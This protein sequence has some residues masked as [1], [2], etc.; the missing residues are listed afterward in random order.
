M[1]FINL[2]SLILGEAE[3]N[4][5]I[6]AGGSRGV[7]KK[8]T[9]LTAKPF[10]FMELREE[11]DTNIRE[12]LKKL[13]DIAIKHSSKEGNE[14]FRAFC[15]E[16]K[17]R[18]P[19]DFLKKIF[20]NLIAN[21]L[22]DFR[23][24]TSSDV[25]TMESIV[26]YTLTS[27]ETNLTDSILQGKARKRGEQTL[28]NSD[29]AEKTRNVL[30]EPLFSYYKKKIIP[31]IEKISE[32]LS[33]SIK[34][35]NDMVLVSCHWTKEE[36]LIGLQYTKLNELFDT[37]YADGAYDFQYTLSCITYAILSIAKLIHTYGADKFKD[38]FNEVMNNAFRAIEDDDVVLDDTSRNFVESVFTRFSE[39]SSDEIE[40]VCDKCHELIGSF[41]KKAL[42]DR[43]YVYVRHKLSH[44]SMSIG[45]SG[46]GAFIKKDV[47]NSAL[48]HPSTTDERDYEYDEKRVFKALRSIIP[49]NS[50]GSYEIP[51]K[52]G[53][54]VIMLKN[55]ISV[56][57]V[58]SPYMTIWLEG[59]D[60]D[61]KDRFG[62]AYSEYSMSGKYKVDFKL[63]IDYV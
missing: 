63:S 10:F 56:Y 1:A 51:V 41:E 39:R 55:A 46:R 13:F 6:L 37:R 5:D 53:D 61:G 8:E 2:S 58:G 54:E 26:N 23:A 20:L 11:C 62:S 32:K 21:Y 4:D 38:K 34:I 44:Q 12:Y 14:P 19:K 25:Y 30:S 45:T 17:R 57:S 15:E 49:T 24:Q 9:Y 31:E 16:H 28:A 7:A 48:L 36:G 50:D 27:G 40:S 33:N 43:T 35:K 60:D 47:S 59:V 3:R 18:L 52:F 22:K 29:I 42:F